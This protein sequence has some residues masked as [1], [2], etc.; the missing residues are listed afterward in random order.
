MFDSGVGGLSVLRQVARSCNSA[1]FIYLGDEARC[2]Y[3]NRQKS[4]IG[5]FVDE[6]VTYLTSFQLDALIM[7]CNTSC[8]M[9]LDVAQ[10]RIQRSP[11]TALFD[12]IEPT[13][14]YLAESAECSKIGVMATFGTVSTRAFSLA[15]RRHGYSGE[16]AEVACPALV[17][18]IESG[19]LAEEAQNELLRAALK[20]YLLSLA[21]S[22]MIILGCTHFPFVASDIESLLLTDKDLQA[23]F[24]EGVKL[25]DPALVLCRRLFPSAVSGLPAE[26]KYAEARQIDYFSPAFTFYTTGAVESFERAAAACLKTPVPRPLHLEVS[27]LEANGSASRNSVVEI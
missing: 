22:S 2:P 21:G 25:I 26:D 5:L 3:G 15:L 8:A 13:A 6:I 17:P 14:Q 23:C 11:A 20:S 16:V 7:A 12:L 10:A 19:K 24:P 18:L 1:Q 27:V 4:E 9:A